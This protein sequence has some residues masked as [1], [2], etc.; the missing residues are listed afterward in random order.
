MRLGSRQIA[1]FDDP[2]RTFAD[3]PGHQCAGADH[4]K[5]RH[6]AGLQDLSRL[7]E[8]EL[9][10][11]LALALSVDGDV[12]ASPERSHARLGPRMALACAMAQ[13]IEQRCNT[14]VGQQSS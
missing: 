8:R 6:L 11:L 12:M 7:L 5:D 2:R 4:A 3:L 1:V 13:S 9:A 10:A 14:A